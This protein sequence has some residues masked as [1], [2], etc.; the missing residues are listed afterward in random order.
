[1]WSPIRDCVCSDFWKAAI[2]ST[3]KSSGR[4]RHCCAL[5][6]LILVSNS[7]FKRLFS[8]QSSHNLLC[9]PSVGASQIW[10]ATKM[11]FFFFPFLSLI[12]SLFRHLLRCQWHCEKQA[13]VTDAFVLTFKHFKNGMGQY[14]SASFSPP[15]L[16]A[17]SKHKKVLGLCTTFSMFAL[18]KAALHLQGKI[19]TLLSPLSP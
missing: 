6:A 10:H 16:F 1:M 18:K 5:S 8:R 14:K 11:F 4:P 7:V 9:V 12:M 3:L 15:N 19:P 17:H 2:S 13:Y